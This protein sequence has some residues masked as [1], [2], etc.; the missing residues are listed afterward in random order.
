MSTQY[1][2]AKCP[3]CTGTYE[4][5][6]PVDSRYNIPREKPSDD[7]E[8]M[9]YEC[10]GEGHRVTIYWEKSGGHVA[11]PVTGKFQS[12]LADSYRD[13]YGTTF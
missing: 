13:I 4:L 10:D 6:P 8:K 1:R 12:D 7:C 5:I 2:K 11:G 9:F 3:D